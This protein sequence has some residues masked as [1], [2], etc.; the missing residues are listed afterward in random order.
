M[1]RNMTDTELKPALR[2]AP[3][4][5]FTLAGLHKK[6]PVSKQIEDLEWQLKFSKM[7]LSKWSDLENDK[8]VHLKEY[9]AAT[10]A[11]LSQF[12]AA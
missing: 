12:K 10:R 2:K 6:K 11:E 5:K 8:W 3:V 1:G 9:Q 7:K 4:K